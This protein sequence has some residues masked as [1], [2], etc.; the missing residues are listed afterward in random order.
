VAIL[1]CTII[2]L[3]GSTKTQAATW[4]LDGLLRSTE[5]A[6]ERWR[7]FATSRLLRRRRRRRHNHRGRAPTRRVAGALMKSH[8]ERPTAA[9]PK[10]WTTEAAACRAARR[11]IEFVADEVCGAPNDNCVIRFA[12][13][14]AS[15]RYVS[16][17]VTKSDACSL[18]PTVRRRAAVTD[19]LQFIAQRDREARHFSSP[20]KPRLWST[21]EVLCLIHTAQLDTTKQFRRVASGGD[22][23]SGALDDRTL[24]ANRPTITGI[25]QLEFGVS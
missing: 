14:H 20:T 12:A 11:E 21:R 15:V 23:N 25:F 13:G 5:R 8:C 6:S 1:Y 4:R 10:K 17:Y 16:V 9:V 24:A 18:R 22:D 3:Y 2:S 7:H 19:E